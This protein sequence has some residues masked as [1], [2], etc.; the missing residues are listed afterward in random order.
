ME[1]KYIGE[2]YVP[3]MTE[4]I[5]PSSIPDSKGSTNL[6]RS[7][8]LYLF[9]EGSHVRLYEKLGAHFVKVE[10]TEGV[11]FGVW[12]PDA[13]RVCVIGDFNG[14]RCDVND[15]HPVKQ[16][17]IWEGFVA[18]AKQGQCY[19]FHITSRYHRYNVEKADPYAFF[20]EV[21]PR[22]ASVIWDLHYA[23]SDQAWMENRQKRNSHSQ[24]ISI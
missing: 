22:T 6:L 16:S 24:P 20:S 4:P 10:Q 15:L 3:A 17:G 11:N 19:K 8:D 18:G 5:S 13:E 2:T 12:A 9:N 1:T 23:W 21:P 14:W 7:D